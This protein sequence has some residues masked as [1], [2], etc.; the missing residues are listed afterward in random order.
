MN[1]AEGWFTIEK[2]NTQI[3]SSPEN[4]NMVYSPLYEG[5]I[6]EVDLV[7]FTYYW[8][9]RENED[10]SMTCQKVSILISK[11]KLLSYPYIKKLYKDS[12][13]HATT[14][15]YV[16]ERNLEILINIDSNLKIDLVRIYEAEIIEKLGDYNLNGNTLYNTPKKYERICGKSNVESAITCLKYTLNISANIYISS[17]DFKKYYFS[18]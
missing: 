3:I 4:I 18:A 16:A 13:V 11:D 12:E 6:L 10:I 17:D 8:R 5:Y 2:W 1:I 15:T 9:R 7:Y 14:G